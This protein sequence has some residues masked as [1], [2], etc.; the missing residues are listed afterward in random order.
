MQA[1][2]DEITKLKINQTSKSDNK[3]DKGKGKAKLVQLI[4]WLE[5]NPLLN[6]IESLETYKVKGF[7]IEDNVEKEFARIDEVR[8]KDMVSLGDENFKDCLTH[9]EMMYV[10]TKDSDEVFEHN[11]TGY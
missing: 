5:P 3:P 11:N 10:I 7:S 6:R 1:M 4:H 2:I 9:N 8:D